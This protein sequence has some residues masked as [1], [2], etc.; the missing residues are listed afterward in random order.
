MSL[1]SPAASAAGTG[2]VILPALTT[3][4]PQLRLP[5]ELRT[6]CWLNALLQCLLSLQLFCIAAMQAHGQYPGNAGLA[7][8]AAVHEAYLRRD[9]SEFAIAVAAFA[10]H[11]A[12]SL[13]EQKIDISKWQ[14]PHEVMDHLDIVFAMPGFL[15][16]IWGLTKR[17]E[18]T[19]ANKECKNK[20]TGNAEDAS[21]LLV[22]VSARASLQMFVRR[23]VR[24]KIWV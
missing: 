2:D 13:I 15:A 24:F 12:N 21:F 14:E 3:Y 11:V 20:Q 1:I 9:E 18:R 23:R 10:K 6:I 16:S 4:A 17:L 19:C 7:L 8:F 22:P 5:N